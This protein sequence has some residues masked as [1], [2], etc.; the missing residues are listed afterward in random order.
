M[1]EIREFHIWIRKNNNYLRSC[2]PDQVAYFALLNGFSRCVVFG[3]VSDRVTHIKR[4]LTFWESPLS[5]NW[6]RVTA[7]ERGIDHAA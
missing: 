2:T 1:D 5:E 7:Y 4:L 3:G 6:M